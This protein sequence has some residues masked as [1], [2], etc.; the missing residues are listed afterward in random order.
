MKRL[1]TNLFTRLDRY[2]MKKFFVTFFFCAFLFTLISVVVDFSDLDSVLQWALSTTGET[3]SDIQA[4]ATLTPVGV[5]ESMRANLTFPSGIVAQLEAN[6][7][8]GVPLQAELKL[9]GTKGEIEFINPLAPHSEH[10]PG[11]LRSSHG[12]TA[13]ISPISTY[14]YQL[15]AV[16]HGIDT[17]TPVPTEGEMV[18]RQQAALDGIYEAAGLRHLRYISE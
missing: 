14:T 11:R 6:M 17:G 12:R 16:L 13:T 7:G 18:L 3:P 1:R 5:D 2:I 8:P 15:G 9:I 4:E 10:M